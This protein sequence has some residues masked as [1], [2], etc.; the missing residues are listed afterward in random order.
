ML[1]DLVGW[2]GDLLLMP[3][4]NEWKSH[5]KLFQQEFHP[6]NSSLYLPHEKKALCAF[7][8]SLLDAPEEWGEHAQQ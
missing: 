8:K 2:S 5:R 3:Y 1:C 7:L 6:S 4:G